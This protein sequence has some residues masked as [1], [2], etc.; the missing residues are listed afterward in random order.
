MRAIRFDKATESNPDTQTTT[1]DFFQ[2]TTG[3][4]RAGFWSSK[5]GKS[6]MNWQKNEMCVLL[7][8]EVHITDAEGRVEKFVAGDTFVVPKGFKG[9]WETVKPTKKIFAVYKPE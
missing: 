7:E 5:P 1:K 2:D 8:G 4:F 9:V 3:F 6:D